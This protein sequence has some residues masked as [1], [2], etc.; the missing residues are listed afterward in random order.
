[1]K[2]SMNGL[3]V[4]GFHSFKGGDAFMDIR[5]F[6]IFKVQYQSGAEMGIAETVTFLTICAVWHL[7]H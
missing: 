4:A 5:L 3:P 7:Q 6:S 2:A 1:M